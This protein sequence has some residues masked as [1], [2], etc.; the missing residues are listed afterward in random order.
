LRSEISFLAVDLGA[1]S[2]RVMDCAWDGNAF[3]LR[4]VHR[5][6][7]NGVRVANGL[8]WDALG[9]WSGILDGLRKFR[10]SS[11][12][13]PAAV[14][15]DA[16]GVD[17]GLLDERG[18]LIGNPY[19]YRDART[20]GLPARVDLDA[21][22]FRSTGVQSMAINT[23]FQ[24]ASM[25]LSADPQ[26]ASAHTLLPIPDLFQYF[27]CG[28]KSAEYTEATTTQLYDPAARAWSGEVLG[29]LQIPPDLFPTVC[30]PGT[31]L[32]PVLPQVLSDCGFSGAF[33]AI[34]VASHDTASAVAAIPLDDRSAFLSS[35]TW[36][37]MGVTVSTPQ[38]GED[39]FRSGC[40]NEGSADGGMLLI[41]NLT[42]LW[43]LQ[44]CMRHWAAAGN[45]IHWPE[46]ERAASAAV[47]FRSLID[48]NAAEFQAPQNMPAAMAGYCARTGQPAPQSPGETARCIF[49][50]LS[51]SYRAT[52]D[53]LE[54]ITGRTL[55][56]IRLVGGGAKN[57]FLCQMTAD[58]CHR[59]VIAGPVEAAAL[60]NALVQAVATGH[61]SNLD[62][63][64]AA[65]RNSCEFFTFEPR[66][67][68]GWREAASRFDHICKLTQ[69]QK[70]QKP[71]ALSSAQ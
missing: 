67:D 36:S 16:W 24:L 44:E 34:A 6:P 59:P 63:G 38:L 11:T 15:V 41:R 50:S 17:F 55:D 28:R 25:V 20:D 43:I 58:A 7:N 31:V 39:A 9:I 32:G 66:A 21:R 60:G 4:E 61:F 47:P 42:G 62:E 57:H 56:T 33:P 2:G 5:F 26:L 19:H 71:A 69:D 40:T 51:L 37:L 8:Y 53:D 35:G 65:L 30:M 27:L 12:K 52:L 1:S 45:A 14:G 18:R 22:L 70:N 29:A 3:F 48:P 54:R 49:E 68:C 64:R 46:I 13:L 10:G 23:S